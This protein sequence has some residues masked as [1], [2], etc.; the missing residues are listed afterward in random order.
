[1]VNLIGIWLKDG[2][3]AQ[4][5]VFDSFTMEDYRVSYGGLYPLYSE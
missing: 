2:V 4:S 3:R 5:Q 1:M